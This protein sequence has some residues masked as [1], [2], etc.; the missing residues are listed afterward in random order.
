MYKMILLTS[1]LTCIETEDI[2]VYIIVSSECNPDYVVME[3]SVKQL[4]YHVRFSCCNLSIE[5]PK[6]VIV[7]DLHL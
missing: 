7:Y 4:F 2:P 5:C 6:Y 3:I 1:V